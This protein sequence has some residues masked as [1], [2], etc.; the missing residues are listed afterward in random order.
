MVFFSPTK[1][2]PALYPTNS[3]FIIFIT[4]HLPIPGSYIPCKVH[5]RY[6]SYDLFSGEYQD[7]E[8]RIGKMRKEAVVAHFKEFS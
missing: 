2:T 1:R 4:S 3:L 6:T 5:D 7:Y 8:R